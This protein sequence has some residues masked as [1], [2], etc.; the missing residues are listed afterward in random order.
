VRQ[1]VPEKL[2]SG[3]N[4]AG[5]GALDNLLDD[6]AGTVIHERPD[7]VRERPRLPFRPS[8]RVAG[9]AF[10]ERQDCISV[11]LSN[12][13]TLN[14]KQTPSRRAESAPL[15][16]LRAV[17]GLERISG[18]ITPGSGR[19]PSALPPRM[20]FAYERRNVISI[21]NAAGTPREAIGQS[22]VDPG[23]GTRRGSSTLSGSPA[24]RCNL[25][26]SLKGCSPRWAGSGRF[27][28]RDRAE[29]SALRKAENESKGTTDVGNACCQAAQ[30]DGP[31]R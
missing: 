19:G 30:R 3:F 11:A 15:D 10:L 28:A 9:R 21:R 6:R 13:R 24:M 27:A 18:S 31:R 5:F 22:A 17:D 25:V 7:G 20:R 26:A 14:L 8:A 23:A 4:V 16:A 29:Q 12:A 1:E 2:A